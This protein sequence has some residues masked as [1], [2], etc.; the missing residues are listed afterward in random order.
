MFSR[1]TQRSTLFEASRDAIDGP[2]HML[3]PINVHPGE[4]TKQRPSRADAY[5]DSLDVSQK[6]LH[7]S[8]HPSRSILAIAAVNNLYLFR[9]N[10][11][12][13]R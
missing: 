3:I 5:V 11:A 1:T 12:R 9:Q 13:V 10:P 6:I 8:W 7:A 4:P 2:Q